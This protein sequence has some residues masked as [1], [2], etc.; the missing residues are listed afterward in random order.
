MVAR[1]IQCLGAFDYEVQYRQGKSHGT[2]DALSRCKMDDCPQCQ[3]TLST[4]EGVADA[5]D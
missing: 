5:V 3:V 4:D 2:A 1:W